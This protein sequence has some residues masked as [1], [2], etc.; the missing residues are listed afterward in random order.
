LSPFHVTGLIMG[1]KT[2]E[3]RFKAIHYDFSDDFI[4]DI[5]EIFCSKFSRVFHS[6]LFGVKI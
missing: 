5:V 4:E 3:E 6:V 2:R 1:D